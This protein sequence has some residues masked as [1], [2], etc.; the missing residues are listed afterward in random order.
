[1]HPYTN[2]LLKAVPSLAL[3]KEKLAVIPGNIPN[4]IE[5]PSGCRFHPRCEYAKAICS[6]EIPRLEE[7]EPEHFVACHRAR[8]LNL[9]S[10]IGVL[11]DE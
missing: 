10:P 2:A 1:M 6:A 9:K 3:R 4:L 11:D 8:E 7:V 5:P